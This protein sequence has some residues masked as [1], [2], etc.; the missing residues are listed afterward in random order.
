MASHDV[1]WVSGAH[2]RFGHLEFIITMEGEL[3]QTPTTV[4]PLHSTS[5]D[6]ITKALEELQLHA[7]EDRTLGRD[8]VIGFDYR[9]L[10][11]QLARIPRT[12]LS[13]EDLG[14][15]TFSFTNVMT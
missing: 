3:A 12:R 11:H 10:E 8:Q 7:S 2:V 9:R 5:L 14:C 6:A 1:S 15:L 13:W 4:Q